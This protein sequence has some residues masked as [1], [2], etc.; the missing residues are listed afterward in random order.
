M[1]RTTERFALIILKSDAGEWRPIRTVKCTSSI[2]DF[3]ISNSGIDALLR[4]KKDSLFE[5]NLEGGRRCSG[6]LT[7]RRV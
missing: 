6:L 7:F 5:D 3:S 2:R 1:Y 4:A